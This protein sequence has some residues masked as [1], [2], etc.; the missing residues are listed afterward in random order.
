ML[1][2]P[3]LKGLMQKKA[4]AIIANPEFK[5]VLQ[6]VV[7]DDF[8]TTILDSVKDQLADTIKKQF[9]TFKQDILTETD[10]KI[11]TQD[12]ASRVTELKQKFKTNEDFIKSLNNKVNEVNFNQEKL[13]TLTFNQQKIQEDMNKT[14]HRFVPD[15]S[16]SPS[17][18]RNQPSFDYRPSFDDRFDP[19]RG[20]NYNNNQNNWNGAIPPQLP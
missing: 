4:K 8:K 19:F 9:D 18:Y 5:K 16:P 1:V 15:D 7:F 20:N 3:A 17:P 10:A 13:I 2:T 11:K 6:D 14:I 12:V